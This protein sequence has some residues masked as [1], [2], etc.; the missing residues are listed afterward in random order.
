M[1]SFTVIFLDDEDF[2]PSDLSIVPIEPETL[3]STDQEEGFSVIEV[4]TSLVPPDAEFNTVRVKTQTITITDG[5]LSINRLFGEYVIVHVESDVTFFEVLNWAPDPF[6]SR[7]ILDVY[8]AGNFS[9]LW[10]EWIVWSRNRIPEITNN[11]NDRFILS[12][13]PGVIVKGSIADIG[14]PIS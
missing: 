11:G 5:R 6:F 3:S 10:P 13:I 7:V 9:I 4:P 14:Y 8:N 12:K 1:E 2:D